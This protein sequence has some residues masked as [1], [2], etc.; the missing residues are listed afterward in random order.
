MAELTVVGKEPDGCCAPAVQE[1]CCAPA[2]KAACCGEGTA[3]GSC[4]CSG[5]VPL[6][7]PADDLPG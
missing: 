4:G 1:T 6:A 5:A 2:A 7:W 3:G